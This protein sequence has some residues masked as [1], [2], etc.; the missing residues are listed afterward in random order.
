MKDEPIVVNE[1]EVKKEAGPQE[2]AEAYNNLVKQY[3]YY[4]VPKIITI[5]RD[6]NTYSL[7]IQISVEKVKSAEQGA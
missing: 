6:D 2:F 7:G 4:L 5:L 1:G 3:G